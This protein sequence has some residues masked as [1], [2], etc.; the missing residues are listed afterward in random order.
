MS[1]ICCKFKTPCL[2]PANPLANTS[3]ENPDPDFFIGYNSWYAGPPPIDSIWDSTGCISQCVSTVSQADADACAANQQLICTT[4]DGG[5]NGGINDGDGWMNPGTGGH[6]PI[7]FSQQETCAVQ[8]PDGNFFSFTVPAG[9]V[10]GLNQGQANNAAFG[11]A[12]LKAR[13]HEICLSALSNTEAC[14]NSSYSG[15]ITATGPTVS[16]F[17]TVWLNPGGGLPPGISMSFSI[18]GPVLTLSGTPTTA[19][20]YTFQITALTPTGDFFTKTF[21]IC[22]LDTNPQSLPNANAGIPYS[23]TLVAVCGGAPLNYQVT[24]GS[25]PPGLSLDQ[26][27]GIISGT[28]TTQGTFAFTVTTQTSAT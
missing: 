6:Y 11:L 1:T 3:A 23:Q 18:G 15:T 8:C 17:N 26:N 24:S 14:I 4:T 12:C 19:G 22:V 20:T 9:A 13:Q 2:D 27:S 16:A 21:S 5:G 28:P 25:L 7:S 10:L